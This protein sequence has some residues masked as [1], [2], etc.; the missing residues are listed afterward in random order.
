MNTRWFTLDINPDPWAIGPLGVGRRNG[1]LYPYVG[2]NAQMDAYKQA[3]KELLADVQPLLEGEYILTFYFWRR[4]DSHESGRKHQADATN[5]IKATEDALQGVLFD[6]D[7]AVR[8]VRGVIVEQHAEAR[9][10]VVVKAEMWDGFDPTQL[11]DHVWEQISQIDSP[12][13]DFDNTWPPV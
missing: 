10:F 2:K 6:N 7:R 8:D 5:L 12:S 11:P 1:K 3:V 13:L 9:P 4:L